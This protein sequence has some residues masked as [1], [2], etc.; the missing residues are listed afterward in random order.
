MKIWNFHAF[1][2]DIIR[3]NEKWQ[4]DENIRFLTNNNI[5]KIFWTF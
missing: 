1:D 4:I 5:I 3:E 2:Y